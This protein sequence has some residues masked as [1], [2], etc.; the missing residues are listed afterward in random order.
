M[1]RYLHLQRMIY[2]TVCNE[3]GQVRLPTLYQLRPKLKYRVRPAA[4]ST[5]S[6]KVF[7]SKTPKTASLASENKSLIRQLAWRTARFP[8]ALMAYLVP[9]PPMQMAIVSRYIHNHFYIW[10]S[11]TH[12]LIH[13]FTQSL[14]HPFTHSWRRTRAFM[15]PK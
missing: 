8:K 5:K 9:F 12:S 13:S 3:H 7:F 1:F 2:V 10:H 6:C 14:I 11:I 15:A 4:Y